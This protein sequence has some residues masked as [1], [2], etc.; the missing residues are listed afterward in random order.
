[1]LTELQIGQ[2][3]RDYPLSSQSSLNYSGLSCTCLKCRVVHVLDP[4]NFGQNCTRRTTCKQQSQE[5]ACAE[6]ADPTRELAEVGVSCEAPTSDSRCCVTFAT[7]LSLTWQVLIGA[8]P[9]SGTLAKVSETQRFA[10]FDVEVGVPGS[11]G[12]PRSWHRDAAS[13]RSSPMLTR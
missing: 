7:C 9:N 1:M 11:L 6:R 10:S 3:G 13:A 2:S 5:Q 8:S 4:D 12:R